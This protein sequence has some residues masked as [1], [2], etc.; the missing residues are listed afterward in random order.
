MDKISASLKKIS[1]NP[2]LVALG[3]NLVVLAIC[4][5]IGSG[6]FNSLDDYFMSSVLTG[7]YGG[8]YDVRMYFVNV[9]YGYFLRP[10]YALFPNVG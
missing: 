8:E 9:V 10:F 4:V 7:A 3:M 2:F 1:N 6:K 5:T